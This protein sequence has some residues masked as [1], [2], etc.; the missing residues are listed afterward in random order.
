ME[1]RMDPS[2][3]HITY[4]GMEPSPAVEAKVYERFERVAKL[5][6]RITSCRVSIEAPH[7]HGNKGKLYTV[8]VNIQMPG[9]EIVVSRQGPRDHG[10]EDVYVAI[11]D[12]FDAARRQLEDRIRIIR[13]DTKLH[14]APP[15][16]VVVRLFP[17]YGFIRSTDGLEVYFHKN[18]LVES[19]FEQLEVGAPVRFVIA[20]G[21]SEKGPQASTVH[22]I[23]K[24]H[25][26]P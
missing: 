16:G 13:G 3:L 11:R 26:P 20:E 17:D 24:H 19:S 14:E 9:A 15:H 1:S 6:D 22:P 21:E 18:S 2:M 12:A 5:H 4:R 10:H 8:A 25:P 23:G 7:R